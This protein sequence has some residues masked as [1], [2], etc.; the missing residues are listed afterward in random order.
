MKKYFV[1]S[2]I[3]GFFDE[4]IVSLNEAGFNKQDPN[5]ILIILGDIFDRGKQPLEIYSFIKS[6][7][8]NRVILVRGNHEYLLIHLLKR[9]YPLVHDYHNGTY[10]T[11]ISIY[12]DPLGEEFKFIS[13]NAGLMNSEL[14]K[15]KAA[16]IYNQTCK[17][18]FTNNKIKEIKRWIQSTRW[19]NYYE[20]DNYVFVHSFIP[21]KGNILGGKGEYYSDWRTEESKEVWEESTWHCP[22]KL[23]QNGCFDKE[24][25]NNKILVCG[26]WHTSDFFN[27]LIY[28]DDPSKQLDVEKNNPIFKSDKYSNLIGLD[29]CTTLTKK[30]NVLVIE[31]NKN[32]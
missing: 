5:H 18:L 27:N 26:H 13:E 17:E 7:P 6:L 1:C 24:I 9:K 14:L 25:E 29:T 21:L 16:E 11:L 4:W 32:Y 23:F 20:L 30:V 3:H 2:D 28:K 15:I 22:Y 10:D 31:S 19:K 8:D 12:K